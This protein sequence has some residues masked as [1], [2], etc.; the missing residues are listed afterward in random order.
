MIPTHIKTD[1]LHRLATVE[2][3]E[4]VKILLAVES[5]SRAWGFESVNSDYDVRFIYTRPKEWYLWIDLEEQ[6]DVIVHE[7]VDEIDLNGWD[8]RKALKLFWKSNHDRRVDSIFDH[9]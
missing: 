7:I 4:N 2:V 3:A 9:L 6:S 5:G 8:I 1:I